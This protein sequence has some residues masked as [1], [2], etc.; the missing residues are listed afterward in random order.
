MTVDPGGA[1]AR[2]GPVRENCVLAERHGPKGP[3]PR[4]R[5]LVSVRSAAEAA[6]AVA[7]GADV[8]DVKEPARGPLG[9]A[10]AAVLAEIA[11]VV[12]GR[13]PLSA[14][15]GE[16]RDGPLPL[17][18]EIAGQ[19]RFIKLGLAG[20]ARMARWPDRWQ[21]AAAWYHASVTRVAVIYADWQAAG[22]PTPTD[23]LAW[24][25]ESGCGALLVD[26]YEK[27]GRGLIDL[28]RLEAIAEL[29]EAARD[30]GLPLAL[31]GSLSAEA[32]QRLLPLEPA[33]IGVRGAACI[34]GRE[35]RLAETR[36]REL[37][38]L[39]RTSPTLAQ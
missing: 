9:A 14:A 11:A 24:A 1:D 27:R 21:Q 17:P 7:G 2:G 5:L 32:I 34:G 16:L 25:A 22:A 39:V 10:D 26:T 37:A 23:T 28:W 15:L 8:V 35:G 3:C 33:L 6:I 38:S 12:A 20:C 30:H 31:A 18:S 13:V 36:V 29:V 19:L 4:T